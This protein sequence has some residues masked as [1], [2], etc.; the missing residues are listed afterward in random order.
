MGQAAKLSK[1]PRKTS[2]MVTTTYDAYNITWAKSIVISTRVTN[3]ISIP[4]DT[5]KTDCVVRII[6][7]TV[8]K[9]PFG[10]VFPDTVI[11]M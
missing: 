7:S 9:M 6:W 10:H 11:L 8:M 5:N 1:G 4:N 3:E 2:V